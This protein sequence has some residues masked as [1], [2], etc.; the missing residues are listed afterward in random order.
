MSSAVSVCVFFFGF[1][2][3]FSW[4]TFPWVVRMHRCWPQAVT[5]CSHC[6][7]PTRTPLGGWALT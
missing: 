1:L 5:R 4:L 2:Q 7:D 6:A 3:S